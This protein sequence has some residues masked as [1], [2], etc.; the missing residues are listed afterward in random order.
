MYIQVLISAATFDD[1]GRSLTLK[2]VKGNL[3]PVTC[4]VGVFV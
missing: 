4:S 1:I 2:D 3:I